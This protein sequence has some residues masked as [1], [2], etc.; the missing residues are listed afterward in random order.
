MFQRVKGTNDFYP[1]DYLA[2]KEIMGKM[3]KVCESYGF[4]PVLTPGIETF[5]LLSAKSGEEVKKQIFMLEKRGAE[6]LSLKPELTPGMT[7]MFVATQRQTPKPV[8]WYSVDR[9]WRYEAPQKGREREFF[10][11]SVEQYG[12]DKPEADAEIINLFVD[13]LLATGI[14]SKDFTVKINHRKLLSGILQDIVPKGKL[15]D[16]M[17]VVDKSS[18]I[19]EKEYFLEME[20]A[21]I[22]EP[23]AEQIRHAIAINGTL[24]EVDK[25]ISEHLELNEIALEGWKNLKQ[26]L[27][28]VKHDNVRIDLSVARG[29][30]YYTGTVFEAF[31]NQGLFRALGGGGRYDQLT[32]VFGGEPCPATG[33]GIGYSTV[34]LL[35]QQKKLFPSPVTGPDFFIAPISEEMIPEAVNIARQLRT[36]YS[37]DIDLMRRKISKQFEYA[38]SIGAKKVIVVGPEEL[39][40]KRFT[41]KDMKTGKEEKKKISEI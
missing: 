40:S 31:D 15:E 30:A 2:H 39:K 11:I 29:L 32:E 20:K 8:K 37:V 21:G 5:K 23:A 6:E 26:I 22:S 16:A 33:F 35:L 7:R 17:R 1:K 14:K 4:L 12:S 24:Q 10:Q 13:C 25:K 38:N 28:M 27:S 36:R 3:A 18:K 34:S 9:M 41:I 19:D